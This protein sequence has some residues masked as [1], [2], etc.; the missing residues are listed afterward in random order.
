MLQCWNLEFSSGEW[1]QSGV[2]FVQYP[3]L[4]LEVSGVNSRVL[5]GFILI[6]S[7]Q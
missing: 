3:V 6:V 7:I 4:E 1:G 5:S 2:E